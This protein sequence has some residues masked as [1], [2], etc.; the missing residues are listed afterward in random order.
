MSVTEFRALDH[1]AIK[2]LCDTGNA[3]PR[4]FSPVVQL[5]EVSKMLVSDSP[6]VAVIFQKFWSTF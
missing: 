1:N 3:P 5:L 6:E 4:S 2:V